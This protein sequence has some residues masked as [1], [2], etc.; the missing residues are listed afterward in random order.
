M[1]SLLD[2]PLFLGDKMY[3]DISFSFV[4]WAFHKCL[5]HWVSSYL[6]IFGSHISKQFLDCYYYFL[7]LI[8]A[9][10]K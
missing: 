3:V 4:I 5:L 2:V 1:Y 7:W 8:K 6:Q 10:F 9:V